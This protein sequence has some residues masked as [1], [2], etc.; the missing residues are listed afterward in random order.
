[1]TTTYRNRRAAPAAGKTIVNKY[2]KAC[3]YCGQTVKAGKGVARFNG[4]TWDTLHTPQSWHGSPVSGSWIGGC[5]DATVVNR[6]DT[7]GHAP[8]LDILLGY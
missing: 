4:N 8:D 5:P 6:V 2:A 1:M 7:G 3:K